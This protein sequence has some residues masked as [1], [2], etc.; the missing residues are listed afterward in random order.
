MVAKLKK[1][2]KN[3][4]RLEKGTLSMPSLLKGLTPYLLIFV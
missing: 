2:I 4:L 1:V 3:V